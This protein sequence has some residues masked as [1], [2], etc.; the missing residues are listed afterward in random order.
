MPVIKDCNIWYGGY[1]LTST[2][3]E[4]T[5]DS[6][7][8]EVDVTTYA[9]GGAITKIGGLEDSTASV[10]T[11]MDTS[12][13]EPAFTSNRGG[14]VELLCATAFPTN[15]VV[16]AG[17]RMYAMRAMLRN[18]KE[19]MKI[20]EAAK[21]DATFGSANAEGVLRG[22]VLSPKISSAVDVDGTAVNIGAQ[23]SG[24]VAYFGVHVFSI[25]GDRAPVFKL[26]SAAVSG[27]VTPADRVTLSA[28]TTAGSGFGSSSTATTNAYWRVSCTLGGTTGSVSFAAFAAIV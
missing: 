7:F 23:A 11:F 16:T 21:I 6:T 8:A 26:Q 4:I 14:V 3:N 17:D 27:F 28:I 5:I 18:Y 12:I 22:Q 2:A 25:S 15:G 20:G 10:M 13:S 9:S 19:P 1:D 24:Q